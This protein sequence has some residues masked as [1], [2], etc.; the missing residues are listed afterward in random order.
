MRERE[1]ER[2]MGERE[3]TGYEP[4]VMSPWRLHRIARLGYE[5]LELI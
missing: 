1:R 4:L 3:A 5:L 2:E